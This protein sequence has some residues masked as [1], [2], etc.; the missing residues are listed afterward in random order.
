MTSACTPVALN[1][2]ILLQVSPLDLTTFFTFFQVTFHPFLLHPHLHQL[3]LKVFPK[4]IIGSRTTLQLI[5]KGCNY[6]SNTFH[7]FKI[8]KSKSKRYQFKI[9]LW[10]WN[11][12]IVK[13]INLNL[14]KMGSLRYL[15]NLRRYYYF[16][17]STRLPSITTSKHLSKIFS[18]LKEF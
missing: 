18:N 10:R 8:V 7:V 13:V 5:S 14:F 12:L 4:I 2:P 11:Y 9:I 1:E 3:N 6:K 17:N 15:S 16:E